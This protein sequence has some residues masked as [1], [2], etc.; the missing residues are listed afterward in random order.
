MTETTPR[1]RLS[2]EQRAAEIVAVATRH[3]AARGYDAVSTAEV[4]DEA[5]VTR[6]LVHHY[7]GDKAG[8]F[9]AVTNDFVESALHIKAADRSLPLSER[10]AA[11]FDYVLDFVEENRTIWLATDGQGDSVD[12]PGVRAVVERGYD[13]YFNRI[14]KAYPEVMTRSKIDKLAIRA[15]QAFSSA[16]LR[17]WLSGAASREQIHLLLTAE[18]LNLLQSTIPAV[19]SAPTPRRA[20]PSSRQKAG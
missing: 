8:L 3:F 1:R 17:L 19:R 12:D 20:R 11:N 6:A 15:F 10:V 9:R 7:F 4:A 13:A 18:L 16:A 5:G 14:V 2:P